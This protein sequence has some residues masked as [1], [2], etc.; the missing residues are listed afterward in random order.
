M[1]SSPPS[2]A[3]PKPLYLLSIRVESSDVE[4]N[5]LRQ[6]IVAKSFKSGLVNAVMVEDSDLPSRLLL[7]PASRLREICDQLGLPML[8]ENRVDLAVNSKAD[9]VLLD[10]GLDLASTRVFLDLTAANQ[11]ENV[12]TLEEDGSPPSVL[13]GRIVYNAEEALAA[14][15]ENVDLIMV[16]LPKEGEFNERCAS[17]CIHD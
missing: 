2:S 1:E 17:S 14:E 11:V 5:Q 10:Q 4:N 12:R 15:E 9:G 16:A 7:K 6:D 13:C 3:L 8:V